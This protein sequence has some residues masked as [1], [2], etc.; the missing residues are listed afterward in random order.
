ML[1]QCIKYN[2]VKNYDCYFHLQYQMQPIAVSK[3]FFNTQ[4][5]FNIF[6]SIKLLLC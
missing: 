6:K 5:Y 4:P 3:Y 1:V 2:N